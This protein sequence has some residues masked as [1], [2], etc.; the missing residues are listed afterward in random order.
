[1]KLL[2]R[3][4]HLLLLPAIVVG[5]VL[6]PVAPAAAAIIPA[7]NGQAVNAPGVDGRLPAVALDG[8]GNAILVWQGSD[9]TD[10]R[11]QMRTRSATGSL[12]PIKTLSAAG[13]SAYNPQ[14]A[15]TSS[16]LAVIVWSRSDGS[17]Y[18]VQAVVRSASG[19]LSSVR[20]LSAAGQNADSAQVAFDPKGNATFAWLRHDGS[21][22]RV[23]VQRRTASGSFSAVQTLSASGHDA[24][25]VQL[26]VE[27]TGAAVIAWSLDPESSASHVQLRRRTTSASLSAVQTISPTGQPASHPQ[28]A[29]DANGNLLATWVRYDGASW[30]AQLRM[31]TPSGT[32]G[33]VKTLSPAGVSASDP[34]AA[35]DPGRNAIVV[36]SRSDGANDRVEALRRTAS[37]SYTA[38]AF[39]SPAG[40]DGISPSV[41]LDRLGNA[42]VAWRAA[43]AGSWVIKVRSR[44]ASGSLGATRTLS[45]AGT[46]AGSQRVAI[47]A[48]G[49][50]LVAWE[51]NGATYLVQASFLENAQTV[52]PAGA[53]TSFPM[54]AVDGTGNAVLVWN[55][56]DGVNYRME[57]RRRSASG[58]LGPIKALSAAGQNAFDAHIVMD[59]NGNAVIAWQRYDGS[60]WRIQV[61][62]R[63]SGGTLSTVRTVSASGQDASNPALGIDSN[64]N[65]IITWT[66]S[67]GANTR[68]Q[69]VRRAAGGTFG[70]VQSLSAAGQNASNPAVGV[71]GNGNAVVAWVRSDGTNT[72]VQARRRSGSGT[73]GSVV[74][75]SAAGGNAGQ[76]A[77]AMKATGEAVV[78]W[79]RW[80][81]SNHRVQVR[82]RSTS[83][84]WSSAQTLSDAGQT[85]MLPQ[86]GIDGNGRAVVVW[87]RSD[88]STNRVQLRTR[89]ATGTLGTVQTLSVAGWDASFPKIAVSTSG[90]SAITWILD[91]GQDYKVELRWR[92]AS[93]T[94]APLQ[95][96]SD[97]SNAAFSEI[98]FDRNANA[99]VTWAWN[100][101]AVPRIAVARLLGG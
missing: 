98:G 78:V 49:N 92:S 84:T 11:I 60:H 89:S 43:D 100:D 40:Q 90:K 3:G 28:L 73:L 34:Q 26:A 74:T 56:F 10:W 37:G 5:M 18:R 30:R 23:Q 93:G 13:E 80:D 17:T 22:D 99:V 52:S 76:P 96:V 44:T 12:G 64:G 67:D 79:T 57:M 61:V 47:D 72:R 65:A 8:R 87:V 70:S 63:S 33:A 42:V 39:V 101:G 29:I 32:L 55:Q 19:S 85:A 86:V 51:A 66:R 45:S 62:R 35:F 71:D 91:N 54:V 59:S 82:R 53:E 14:I 15:R 46:D 20:T 97:T 24:A 9:G 88:G 41:A 36:W 50:A 48:A 38:A 75:L 31:R 25:D 83:G 7:V 77:L 2:R 16:G 6:E 58:S 4:L 69:V 68:V 27:P 94:V 21:H 1:M 81:G 95:R